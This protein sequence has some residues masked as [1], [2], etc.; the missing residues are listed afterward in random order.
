MLRYQ[1]EIVVAADRYVCLQ[2][3]GGFPEGRA[4]V[5]VVFPGPESDQPGATNV[6]V[7]VED[8]VEWWEE[9]EGDPTARD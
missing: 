1:T 5:V 4:R 6:G 7:E 3:P 8:D 2:L 9:F